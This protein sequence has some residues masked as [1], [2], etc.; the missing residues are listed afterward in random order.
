MRNTAYCG[1][2]PHYEVHTGK[3][4]SAQHLNSVNEHQVHEIERIRRL[5]QWCAQ[6]LRDTGAMDADEFASSMSSIERGHGCARHPG[7]P[8]VHAS[9]ITACTVPQPVGVPLSAF[10]CPW[11]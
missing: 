11:L 5:N 10:H 1:H 8:A 7:V 6:R 9:I 3:P 2:K 4:A